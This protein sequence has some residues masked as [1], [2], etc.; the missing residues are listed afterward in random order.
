MTQGGVA[1]AQFAIKND[2]LKRQK[3]ECA[4][5][6]DWGHLMYDFH[7]AHLLDLVNLGLRINKKIPHSDV[8]VLEEQNSFN[9]QQIQSVALLTG[10]LA[11]RAN[12]HGE[13]NVYFMANRISG[14]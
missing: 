7:K 10:L 4:E 5:I 2:E 11:N 9:T 1:W 8:Y 12:S 3:T 6:V 14:Q 13:K